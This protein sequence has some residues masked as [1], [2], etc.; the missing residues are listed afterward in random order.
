MSEGFVLN[1]GQCD[2]YPDADTV[3]LTEAL[4][5]ASHIERA[6]NWP[7]DATRVADR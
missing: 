6:E 7:S 5:I 4:R 1:G 3:P 2:A